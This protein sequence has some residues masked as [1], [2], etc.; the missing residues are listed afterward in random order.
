MR[1]HLLTKQVPAL[2][3]IAVLLFNIT[4]S[5]AQDRINNNSDL[6]SPAGKLADKFFPVG[7]LMKIGVFYYPEQWPEEQWERDFKNMAKFGF[8]F[9]HMAEFSWTRLEPEEGKFDFS[10]LDKAID[11]AAKAGLKV[12][13]CTPS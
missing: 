10:W 13:L 12:I 8:E 4:E 9:T 2:A 5:K 6:G 11:L 1:Y 7:D 3:C